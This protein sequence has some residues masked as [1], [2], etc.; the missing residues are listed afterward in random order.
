M[1]KHVNGYSPYH[2]SSYDIKFNSITFFNFISFHS[3]SVAV[4]INQPVNIRLGRQQVSYF[5]FEV[6]S[7]G[8]SITLRGLQGQMVL[9]ASLKTKNPSSA[10]HEYTIEN[11]GEIYIGQSRTDI[12]HRLQ[13]R[14]VVLPSTQSTNV[15]I[16]ISVE[17]IES[18]NNF[19]VWGSEGD[20]T[21][22]L[23]ARLMCTKK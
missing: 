5:R 7:E 12:I 14:E 4:D 21:S 9:Y 6:P 19:F 15:T 3:A 18:E 10:L 16:Y 22:K 8:L 11:N 20:I 1:H 13:K 23:L 17:G 2:V